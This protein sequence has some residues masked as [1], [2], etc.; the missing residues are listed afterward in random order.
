M[1]KGRKALI[2][3]VACAVVLLGAAAAVADSKRFYVADGGESGGHVRYTVKE[4]RLERPGTFTRV[5]YKA[6]DTDNDGL[7]V[8]ANLYENGVP[9]DF[10]DDRNGADN[11]CGPKHVRHL[12]G[13]VRLRVCLKD[14]DGKQVGT[15]LPIEC[16][17][18]NR[19]D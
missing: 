4:V 8:L 11:G 2:T 19:I 9:V 5:A 6:C 15:R 13:V 3:A 16:T 1:T 18:K 7:R 10:V 12:S 14:G 17:T